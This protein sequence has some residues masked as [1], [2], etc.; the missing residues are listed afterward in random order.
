M[1]SRGFTL[2][3]LL[4]VLVIIGITASLAV[5]AVGGDGVDEAARD[6]L[7][8]IAALVDL[9]SEQAVLE[10]REY[11]VEFL[12]QG[13][14]F[15]VYQD[16]KWSVLEDDRLLR[17]REIEPG[18]DLSLYVEDLPVRLV[19]EAGKEPAPQLLLLS[20]GERTPFELT[21]TPH[22]TP[23]QRRLSGG[24]FDRLQIE[25]LNPS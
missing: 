15:V 8:R 25:S 9:A 14:H 11:G 19:E 21:I 10:S 2:I 4:V 22:A 5:I 6:E 23:P 20:S 1:V 24:V 7:R 3:E 16:E 17:P 18:L 13:Y 12:Q